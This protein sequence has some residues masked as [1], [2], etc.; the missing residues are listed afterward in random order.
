MKL[1]AVA[2]VV[3][4]SLP[5]A[6]ETASQDSR[7]SDSN[8][9]PMAAENSPAQSDTGSSYP[10]GYQTHARTGTPS[11]SAPPATPSEGRHPLRPRRRGPDSRAV[12]FVSPGGNPSNASVEDQRQPPALAP[13]SPI[14]DAG[15]VTEAPSSAPN[16]FPAGTMLQGPHAN[17]P[18][19]PPRPSPAPPSPPN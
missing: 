15:I 19:P 4:C 13:R 16:E 5:G 3:A 7:T 12:A 11:T 9:P 10:D 6:A 1:I 8:T 2:A 17:R 18:S 14:I